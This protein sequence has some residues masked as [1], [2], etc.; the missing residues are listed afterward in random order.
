MN[1]NGSDVTQQKMNI[2]SEYS[3]SW[4]GVMN[5]HE[6]MSIFQKSPIKQT[7]FCKRDDHEWESWMIMNPKW[8]GMNSFPRKWIGMYSF[9]LNEFNSSKWIHFLGNQ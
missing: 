3:W 7:M 6:S 5:D 9:P 1:K 8:I 2:L 4:M